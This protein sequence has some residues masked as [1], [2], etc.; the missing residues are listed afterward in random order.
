VSEPEVAPTAVSTLPLAAAPIIRL[1]NLR[2]EVPGRVLLEDAALDVRRGE[3]I[4]VV[5]P[6]GA[7]K[8]VLLRLLTG[9]LADERDHVI[10][11]RF[12]LAGEDAL[13]RPAAAAERTGLVLN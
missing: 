3:T 9:L 10:S 7:G 2:V 1:A 13:A 6:S 5:G 12:E 8:S 11:G 4:L